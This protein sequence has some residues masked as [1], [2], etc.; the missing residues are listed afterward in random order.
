M[1][2]ETHGDASPDGAAARMSLS[3]PMNQ[4]AVGV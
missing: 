3:N 1:G 2:S 4:L